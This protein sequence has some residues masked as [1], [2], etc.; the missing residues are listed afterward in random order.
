MRRRRLDV[1]RASPPWPGKDMAWRSELDRYDHCLA[2]A[3]EMLDVAVG[4][5]ASGPLTAEARAV[6]DDRLAVAGLD[7]FGDIPRPIGDVLEE[8]Y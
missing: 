4:G 5:P 6:L 3:A 1:Y 8:D 7:V 2:V